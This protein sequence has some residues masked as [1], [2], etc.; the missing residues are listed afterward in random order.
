MGV[1]PR[2]GDAGRNSWCTLTEVITK[3][4]VDGVVEVAT[5][6]LTT[7]NGVTCQ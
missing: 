2:V 5:L 3:I 6:L 4:G 7:P 1:K